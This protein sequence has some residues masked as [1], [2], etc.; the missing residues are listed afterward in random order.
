[1]EVSLRLQAR[2][3]MSQ[4]LTRFQTSLL[5]N[6]EPKRWLGSCVV[7]SRCDTRVS[8]LDRRFFP[9]RSTRDPLK[10]AVGEGKQDTHS[11]LLTI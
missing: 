6:R 8:P 3:N 7:S 4:P 11:D 9:L 1:M 5:S 2:N 10:C